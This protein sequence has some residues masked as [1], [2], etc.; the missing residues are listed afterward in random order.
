MDQLTDQLRHQVVS[1]RLPAG[2]PLPS[3]RELAQAYGVGRTTVRESLHRLL[4]T[5]L[6]D[7]RGAQLVVTDARL[8]QLA[9]LDCAALAERV[10]VRDVFELRALLEGR[11]VELAAAAWRGDELAPLDALVAAMR[12]A[13]DAAAYHEAHNELHH[14]IMALSGNPV[15]VEVYEDSA[16][17]F[18]QL[19]SYWRVFAGATAPV[20]AAHDGLTRGR[21]NG[22]RGHGDLIEAIRARDAR[23]AR[24][25]SDAMLE[26]V[27]ATLT[28][29]AAVPAGAA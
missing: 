12:D 7:R 19:P 26:R 5:G 8:A 13:V 2:E 15:L 14:R 17:M 3:E 11:A 16:A 4:A 24:R 29:R 10:S 28:D 25:L 20:D 22:W 21:I 18:F 9:E 6:V 23:E 1:G 27:L